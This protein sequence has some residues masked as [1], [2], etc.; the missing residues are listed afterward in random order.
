[1]WLDAF[2]SRTI[3]AKILMP[4]KVAGAISIKC[5]AISVARARPSKPGVAFVRLSI[6]SDLNKE[7]ACW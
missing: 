5:R 7:Q 6:A 3:I 1:M 2:F 4:S